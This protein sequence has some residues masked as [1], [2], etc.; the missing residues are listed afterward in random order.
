[1]AEGGGFVAEGGSFVAEGGGLGAQGEGL[2]AQGVGEAWAGL[3]ESGTSFGSS[4]F[5]CRRAL[6]GRDGGAR[7]PCG[8][9]RA[10]SP[11]GL[12]GQCRVSRCRSSF[13][14]RKDD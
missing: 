12:G 13:R 5:S 2:G 6:F 11:A 9:S 7:A 4:R 1:M 3:W 8:P 14:H 10:G